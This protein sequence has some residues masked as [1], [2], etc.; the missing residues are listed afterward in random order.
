[1]DKATVFVTGDLI[2]DRNAVRFP[3]RRAGYRTPCPSTLE[4]MEL[5]GA[6]YT[7]DILNQL[8][9]PKE[10][11]V[12]SP[13]R[14]KSSASAT[15]LTLWELFERKKD[16]KKKDWRVSEF[17]GCQK[18]AKALDPKLLWPVNRNGDTLVIDDV[19]LAFSSAHACYIGCR[20]ARDGCPYFPL[21]LLG[22]SHRRSAT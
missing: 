1:M 17:V 22:F 18:H 21:P 15:A 16:K 19:G 11:S 6:W 2:I 13:K 20:F 5:G 14:I 12:F 3:I 7:A 4:S 8:I 9:S 10:K